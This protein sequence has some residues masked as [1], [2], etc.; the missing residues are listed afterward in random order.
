MAQIS[1]NYSGIVKG[2]GSVL[3]SVANVFTNP[4]GA[5]AGIAG[6]IMDA[7]T[8]SLS[9]NVQSGGAVA[10][11]F[12]IDVMSMYVESIHYSTVLE[13]PTTYGYP[14][15]AYEPLTGYSGYVILAYSDFNASCTSTEKDQIINYL[16]SG[17][18]L[19]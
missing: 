8:A 13:S 6:G 4:A 11:G 19:E 5:F 3:G 16:E 9:P 7:V 12:N 17:V 2:A 18:F 14:I 15:K 10:G 1:T